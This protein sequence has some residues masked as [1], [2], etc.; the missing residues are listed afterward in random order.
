MLEFSLFFVSLIF[1]FFFF[2]LFFFFFYFFFF[3]FFFYYFVFFSFLVGYKENSLFPTE[4]AHL[5][6]VASKAVLAAD[7][8][9]RREVVD[10]LSMLQ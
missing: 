8:A 9:R 2:F 4:L 5:N 1:Y 10:S 7:L 3:F 6:K